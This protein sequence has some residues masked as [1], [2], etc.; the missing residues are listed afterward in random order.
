MTTPHEKEIT[1]QK[2]AEGK[3]AAPPCRETLRRWV[4]K[5]RIYPAP[6]KVGRDYMVKPSAEYIDPSDT[7]SIIERINAAEKKKRS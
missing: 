2:W 3:F 4:R 7:N 1:L 6:R 5:A